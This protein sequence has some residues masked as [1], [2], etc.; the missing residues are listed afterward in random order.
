M[1]RIRGGAFPTAI[2]VQYARRVKGLVDQNRKIMWDAWTKRIKP[3]IHQ[4][5]NRNDALV[6]DEDELS[7][8][9]KEL[10]AL[11]EETGESVFVTA[12][13]SAIVQQFVN[14]L[15]QRQKEEFAEQFRDV[16]GI[17]P[18]MNESW[19]AS[20]METAVAENVSRIKSIDRQ[21]HDDIKTIVI[22]GVRSG[23]SLNDMAER[24]K[25]TSGAGKRRAI[26]I[27][28][29]Q[30]GS[31]LGDMTKRRHQE[32]GLKKFRWRDSDDRRVRKKH[33]E[34][35]GK[36]FTWKDGANGLYPGK[37]YNCRCVAEPLEEE[38]FEFQ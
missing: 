34:L 29:D 22:Q 33:R 8:I 6:L 21:Y 23:E 16:V 27:A 37:D 14:G 19:L 35:D 32:A 30:T 7:D 18:T 38:L 36:V 2:A 11:E 4:Y 17:D 13:V 12:V 25:Q 24:I 5:R 26:F 28:R 10:E 31:I 9:Q 20:F 1:A 15:N 3:L